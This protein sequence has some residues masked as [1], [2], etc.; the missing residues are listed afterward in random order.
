MLIAMRGFLVIS[1]SLWFMLAIFLYYKLVWY[2]FATLGA[3][4]RFKGDSEHVH[5]DVKQPQS[6]CR[7]IVYDNQKKSCCWSRLMN[8]WCR[9]EPIDCSR[10]FDDSPVFQSDF[11]S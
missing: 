9:F 11:C 7:I 1:L 3:Q 8:R 2:I 6:C 4:R 10:L 5:F